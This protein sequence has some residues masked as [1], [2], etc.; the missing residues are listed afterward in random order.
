[1]RYGYARVSTEGQRL[2]SQIEELRRAGVDEI[3]QGKIHRHD[4]G[5]AG[6]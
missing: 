5:S 6:F 1:M 2:E 3:Y 4:H